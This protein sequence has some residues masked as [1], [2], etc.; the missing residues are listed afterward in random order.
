MVGL[1]L[2]NNNCDDM[3]AI[4]L[5]HFAEKPIF[6]F[7]FFE[8]LTRFFVENLPLPAHCCEQG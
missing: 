5:K 8:V 1:C 3:S 6:I 4:E 7:Y 2:L